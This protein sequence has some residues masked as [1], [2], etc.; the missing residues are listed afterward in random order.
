MKVGQA[1]EAARQWVFEEV[2]GVPGFCGAYTAG[3]TN[4]LPDDADLATT[5]DLDVMVVLADSNRASK[6]KKLIYRNT[7]IEVSYLR[8]DQ[9]R[10]SELVL[11]DYHLAPSFATT[12]IILDPS[13][14]LTALLAAVRSDYAKRR[15]VK[16]RCA[17]A[18]N[19]VLEYL[20]S[21][22]EEWLL[23]DQV[24]ACLFAAGITTHVLLVA[25]LRNP[26]VRARY[27]AVR[28]LLADYGRLE[29]QDELLELLGC[30]QI[31][32][33]RVAQH[34][35]TLMH[36]FEAAK[37]AIR[38]PFPFASDIRDSGRP[39]AIDGSLEMIEC[40]YDREAMF[41]IAVTHSRCHKTL[42]CDA[43]QELQQSFRNSYMDLL[44]D[45]GISSFTEIR[46]RCTEIE[47]VLSRVWEVAEAI[48]SANQGI[49]D[50]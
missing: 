11:S 31:H 44:S 47:R 5:S 25:G 27:M 23:H 30:A 17:N 48:M 9:F 4:W 20:R 19:K 42:L 21:I 2:S 38:T 1:R 22:N 14:H 33:R 46:Q 37:E 50:D 8:D 41:W 28:E 7:L 45:L 12:N 16:T 18:R 43:S 49:E 40:G 3:S 29:F 32:R 10:L 6:R 15:W 39:G 26:T 13:G 34:L 24:I 36:L 35:A